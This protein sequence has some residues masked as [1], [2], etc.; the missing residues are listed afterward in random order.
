MLKN[1]RAV[2]M[3]AVA[4]LLLFLGITDSLFKNA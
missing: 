1:W 2:I 4:S 3:A